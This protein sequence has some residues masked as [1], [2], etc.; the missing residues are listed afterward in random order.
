MSII[1]NLIFGT[2][3]REWIMLII[4][5]SVM[6]GEWEI[7][8]HGFQSCEIQVKEADDKTRQEEKIKAITE[9]D[10]YQ[11]ETTKLLT[12]EKNKSA[13]LEDKLHALTALPCDNDAIGNV[14]S[15]LFNS[16]IRK[17]NTPDSP[18]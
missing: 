14:R 7:Y 10:Q 8:H 17:T 2:M 9:Q 15:S 12:D 18:R 3:W 11:A 16:S 4:F 6:F 13:T 1:F 5:G